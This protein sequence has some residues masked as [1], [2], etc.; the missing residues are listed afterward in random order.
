MKR[1]PR[2]FIQSLA[3]GFRILE[4][5][6]TERPR[7]GLQELTDLTGMNKTTVQRLTDTLMTLGYLGRN[8]NKDFYMEPKVL[9]LGF[10]YLNGS[11]LRH[12]AETHLGEFSRRL[13][14]TVNLAVLDGTDVVFIYR[15]EI[16]RF[17]SFGIR[18]GSRLPAYCTSSGKVLLA[19][20]AEGELAERIRS[21]EFKPLTSRT[22]TDPAALLAELARTRER[23]YALCD[24]EASLALYSMAAPLINLRAEVVAAINISLSAEETGGQDVSGLIND[25]LAEG[26]RLSALLGYQGSYPWP[27]PGLEMTT[28]ASE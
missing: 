21:M 20:L 23:G 22:I 17:F 11:E 9:S 8:R 6:S 15:H 16:Q 7:L 12:L 26:R 27:E 25:L 14:Q 5:F 2:H 18:E 4:C 28:R 10:A 1:R 19:A 13:G 24:R 3:R